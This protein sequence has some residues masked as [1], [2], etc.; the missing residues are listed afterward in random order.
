MWEAKHYRWCNNKK[1][2][3]IIETTKRIQDSS[4]CTLDD[5]HLDPQLIDAVCATCGAKSEWLIRDE[6]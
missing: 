2:Y 1:E 5:C 6:G 3:I 4:G